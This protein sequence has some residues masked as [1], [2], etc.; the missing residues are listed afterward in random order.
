M[1][2]ARHAAV[3]WR[4]RVVTAA[5][6]LLGVVLAIAASYKVTTS[7][8]EPR[9]ESTYSSVSQ[10]MV[11]QPGFP[12]GRVVLPMAPTGDQ[13]D[14]ADVDPNRLEFADPSRFMALA[15]LYTKLLVSDEVRTRI[16]GRP[17]E[18]QIVASPLPAVSGAPILPIIQLTV[19]ARSSEAATQLNRDAVRSLQ[20]LLKERQA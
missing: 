16:P 8:V 17:K 7:G 18:K 2:L 6:V 3:L 13:A 15:D 4:Y 9:G 14:Q 10:V 12:E 5:C 19:T 20:K 11:T 1:N